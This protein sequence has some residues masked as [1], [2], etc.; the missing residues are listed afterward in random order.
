M[1]ASDIYFVQHFWKRG[2]VKGAAFLALV[3]WKY[4]QADFGS[5]VVT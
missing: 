5:I 1:E 2:V 3:E 4:G